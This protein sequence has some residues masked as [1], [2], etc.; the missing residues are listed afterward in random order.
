MKDWG[1]G[2]KYL[3]IHPLLSEIWITSREVETLLVSVQ[4]RVLDSIEAEWFS[5]QKEE[6][7]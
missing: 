1:A 5:I 6:K 4:K 2:A 7:N 3:Q